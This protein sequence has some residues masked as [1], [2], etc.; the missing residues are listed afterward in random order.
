MGPDMDAIIVFLLL[1]NDC[2]Q[3]FSNQ[4]S[5]LSKRAIFDP[6]DPLFDP[7]GTRKWVE[8]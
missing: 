4:S 8:I 7:W 1:N 3:N 5:F 2:M 6:S